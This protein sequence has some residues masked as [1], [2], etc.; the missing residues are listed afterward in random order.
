VIVRYWRGNDLNSIPREIEFDAM[1]RAQF[2]STSTLTS[3]PVEKGA[4]I[5]DHIRQ[6]PEHATYEA[7]VSNTPIV[8]PR[9]QTRGATGTSQVVSVNR[10]VAVFVKPGQ[11]EKQNQEIK[12]KVLTFDREFDRC[13]DVYEELKYVERNGILC[14]VE[15]TDRPGGLIDMVEVVITNLSAPRSVEDGTCQ[16][17]TFDVQKPNFVET[18]KVATPDPTKTRKR[19]G[20]QTKKEVTDPKQ[21]EKKRSLAKAAAPEAGNMAGNWLNSLGGAH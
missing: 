6:S 7:I 4:D 21:V 20:K 18:R 5:N 9:T 8:A 11:I 16:S 15:T 14:T 19:R 17:F 1:M 2:T 12:L 10:Q 3:H 13:V